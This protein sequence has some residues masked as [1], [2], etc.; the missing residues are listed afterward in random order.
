[1]KNI[2]RQ[3]EEVK[4]KIARPFDPALLKEDAEKTLADEMPQVA[5]NVNSLRAAKHYE[6]ALLEISRLRPFIDTFFD[7]VMVMVDD[8]ELRAHR[9]GLLQTLVDEF[10]S[11]ADFSEIVT[12]RK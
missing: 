8:E 7:K 3:A 9:L 10:S 11:I 5:A 12:E 6:Q 1:M 2:L 4:R